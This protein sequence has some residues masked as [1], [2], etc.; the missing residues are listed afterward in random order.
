[1]EN[2]GLFRVIDQNALVHSRS[3]SSGY[4]RRLHASHFTFLLLIILLV[5][6]L[7]QFDKSYAQSP[8]IDSMLWVYARQTR[9]D[10]ITTTKS[11]YAVLDAYDRK[12]AKKATHHLLDYSRD[13]N[14]WVFVR[15]LIYDA[16]NSELQE[17]IQQLN[18]AVTI[19]D[20]EKLPELV[21][22]AE[23]VRANLYKDNGV[24]DSAMTSILRARDLY[25]TLG[26]AFELISIKHTIADLF[27]EAGNIDRAEKLYLEIVEKKGDP[28]AW[29][30]WR[31]VVITNDLALIATGRRNFGRAASLFRESEKYILAKNNGKLNATDSTQ[32][33]Y[34]YDHL[35]E[36]LTNLNDYKGAQECYEKASR[37]LA[38]Q[39]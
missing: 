26:D 34:V 32:L 35:T 25:E 9:D 22:M 38:F 13:K 12:I 8:A 37:I 4:S 31:K 2:M 23:E 11:F 33:E 19:G 3:N 14:P 7:C 21:A 1:M 29:S 27:Y 15:S 28:V 20:R 30:L 5:L 18:M 16:N 10:Q 24:Y 39:Q 17:G 6:P 36:T